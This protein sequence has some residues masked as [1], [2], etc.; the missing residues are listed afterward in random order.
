MSL[1]DQFALHIWRVDNL[2][3]AEQIAHTPYGI[4]HVKITRIFYRPTKVEIYLLITYT[5][6]HMYTWT[7]LHSVLYRWVLIQSAAVR[8]STHPRESHAHFSDTLNAMHF[9]WD[10]LP[11]SHT[12]MHTYTLHTYNLPTCRIANFPLLYGRAL[13]RTQ[14]CSI[15][16]ANGSIELHRPRLIRTAR[17]QASSTW[18]QLLKCFSSDNILAVSRA[19]SAECL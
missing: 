5:K 4:F 9:Q 1:R 10:N 3:Q 7:G 17:E 8:P 14:R 18:R 12:H 19:N 13:C 16:T 2:R 11:H 6:I 15:S